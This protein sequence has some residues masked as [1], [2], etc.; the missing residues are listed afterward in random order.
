LLPGWAAADI[1]FYQPLVRDQHLSTAQWQQILASAQQQGMTALALQ[2]GQYGEVAFYAETGPAAALL[3]AAEQSKLPLWLGLY[4]DPLYFQAMTAEGA[5]KKQYFKQQLS[6]SL[7]VRRKWLSYI[8]RHPLQ[9]Q[10]WYFPMELNDTDFVD[11]DYLKWLKTEFKRIAQVVDQPLA[12]SLYY[13]AMVPVA[14]WIASAEQIAQS[15]LQL[16]VQDGYGVTQPQQNR[17]LLLKQLPCSFSVIAEQFRQVSAADQVFQARSL[18]LAEQQQQ[19]RSCH[20]RILFE[21]RYMPAAAGLL[22]LTDPVDTELK[23]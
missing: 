3:A 17:E 14:H 5:D 2:W 10:G 7:E 4:A 6:L 21:L 18:T 20:P 23:P 12:I 1:V 19:S 22:P 16:W 9:L 15:K 13:N 8:A 11:A